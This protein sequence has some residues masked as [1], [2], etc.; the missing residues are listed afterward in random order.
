[1]KTFLRAW[2]RGI[3]ALGLYLCSTITICAIASLVNTLPERFQSVV[4]IP[5]SVLVVPPMLHWTF[6]WLYPDSTAAE[7]QREAKEAGDTRVS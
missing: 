7:R 2:W 5:V 3:G 6:R 4:G 1:M